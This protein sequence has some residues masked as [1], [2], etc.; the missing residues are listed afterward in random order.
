MRVRY[1]M[2]S[3]TGDRE[4]GYSEY[5]S[6]GDKI[7][8]DEAFSKV[9][10][11]VVSDTSGGQLGSA[12]MI[13]KLSYLPAM[14]LLY[15]DGVHICVD[16]DLGYMFPCLE[17][18]RCMY[19]TCKY[20]TGIASRYI[21]SIVCSHKLPHGIEGPVVLC[22]ELLLYKGC[23]SYVL[24][25]KYLHLYNS[26]DE[27]VG[28]I[29]YTVLGCTAL[30]TSQAVDSKELM[31]LKSSSYTDVKTIVIYCGSMNASIDAL[32]NVS[33]I[34]IKVSDQA[35]PYCIRV[36]KLPYDPIVSMYDESVD[37]VESA[38]KVYYVP[39]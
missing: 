23:A 31:S 35:A 6:D 15:A 17:D 34:C 3:Y 7:I 21:R 26:D 32:L 10:M 18:I 13:S 9:C 1:F 28:N 4:D 5:V 12:Y 25:C 36:D 29:I 16:C 11:V 2:K 22:S 27:S 33:C 19:I 20:D 24:S 39:V 14:R 30:Y 37:A 38:H 8:D